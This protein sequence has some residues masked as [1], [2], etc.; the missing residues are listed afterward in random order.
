MSL[1]YESLWQ[2]CVHIFIWVPSDGDSRWLMENRLS[3]WPGLW[4]TL[5]LNIESMSVSPAQYCEL[6]DNVLC[7]KHV[8][9]KY[10]P[11]L[12]SVYKLWHVEWPYRPAPGHHVFFFCVCPLDANKSH[13]NTN[14]VLVKLIW[15]WLICCLK[16]KNIWIFYTFP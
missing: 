11:V 13:S 2:S 8:T 10:K 16:P 4:A 14:K 1:S 6:F 5:H 7:S 15:K 12:P 3:R 9:Q